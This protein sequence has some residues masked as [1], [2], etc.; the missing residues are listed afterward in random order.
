MSSRDWE[1]HYAGRDPL[2]AEPARVLLD[3]AHLLPADG[4]A[5]DLACGL[6][7]NALFLARHGL[8]TAAW[9]ASPTAIAAL[10][11]AAD[12]AGLSLDAEVRDVIALPPPVAAFDVIVVSRFL[13][14][15]LSPVLAAAL[16]PNGLLFYQTFGPPSVDPGRGPRC[17]DF[18]LAQGE[19]PRLFPAL[20]LRAYREEGAFGDTKRGLRDEAYAVFSRPGAGLP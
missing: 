20:E 18:R 11:R 15:A 17:A 4:Y 9:D 1:A 13:A 3:H 6:G 10:A 16:K 12:S 19:L 14:R 2:A 7:A 8:R 5:L